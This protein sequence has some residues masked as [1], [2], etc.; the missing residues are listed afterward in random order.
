MK[1]S[2]LKESDMGSVSGKIIRLRVAKF[3]M[4]TGYTGKLLGKEP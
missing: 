1:E 2:G 4:G 3:T